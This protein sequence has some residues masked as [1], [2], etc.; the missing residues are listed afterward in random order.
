MRITKNMIE[1]KFKKFNEL[2]FDGK[3]ETPEFRLL[4][5]KDGLFGKFKVYKRPIICVNASA[6]WSERDFDDIVVH[7]M[8][9]Y[10][11]YSVL[12]RDPFFSHGLLFRKVRRDIAKKGIKVHIKYKHIKYINKKGEPK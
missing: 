11:I 7:E 12:K 6:D 8:I 5:N 3:L 4:W 1:E 10:Y 9:H 2:Y